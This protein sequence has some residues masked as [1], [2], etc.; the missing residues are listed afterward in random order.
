M[1]RADRTNR[2]GWTDWTDAA[3]LT[4]IAIVAECAEAV[5]PNV[6]IA[7]AII[8]VRALVGANLSR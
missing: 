3:V 2:V 7:C 1:S 4:V 8:R 6:V 5:G